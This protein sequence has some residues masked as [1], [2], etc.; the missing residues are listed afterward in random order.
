MR[1]FKH[2]E[3]KNKLPVRNMFNIYIYLLKTILLREKF[4][5]SK[6]D[7]IFKTV[8]KQMNW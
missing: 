1:F 7:R 3:R 4:Q 8:K 6:E 5:N 2:S